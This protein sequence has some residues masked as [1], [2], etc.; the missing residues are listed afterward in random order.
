M[1]S[2][3]LGENERLINGKRVVFRDRIP[4]SKAP[5]LP[6]MLEAIASD[7]RAVARVGVV[8][9]QEWEFEGDPGNPRSYEELDITTEVLPLAKEIGEYI[10]RRL[11]WA[12][13]KA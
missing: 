10:A 12:G 8:V 3:Q 5:T 2:D 11:D 1:V 9:V 13:G 7:L 4:L 6:K